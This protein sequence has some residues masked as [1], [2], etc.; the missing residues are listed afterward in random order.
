VSEE[1]LTFVK[2]L[3][4]EKVWRATESDCFVI[5]IQKADGAANYGVSQIRRQRRQNWRCRS[6]IK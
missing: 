4:S 6:P 3:M 1:L 2:E 5:K